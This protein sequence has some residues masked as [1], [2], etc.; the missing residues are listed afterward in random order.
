MRLMSL[1]LPRY[2]AGTLSPFLARRV[3]AALAADP[4]LAAAYDALR[5]AERA[6]SGQPLSSGQRETLEAL[7][8]SGPLSGESPAP[9]VARGRVG[10]SAWGSALA[11]AAVVAFAVVRVDPPAHGPGSVGALEAR[12]AHIA[13]DPVGVKVSCLT[14]DNAIVDTATAGARRALDVL[15]C[16][17]SSLLAFSTTNLSHETRQVFVVGVAPDGS[18]RWYAPFTGASVAVGPGVIDNV[19][20]SLADT[21]GMPGGDVTLFVLVSDTAFSADQLERQL[22]KSALPLGHLDRLP[23]DVPLQ[24]RIELTP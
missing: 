7:L 12:G 14:R 13:K 5:R 20:P 21:L 22:K 24:A 2:A 10:W 18:R 19:L 8:F 15:R 4:A 6:A 9:A 11:A 23:V 1:L 16:P 17:A 3:R